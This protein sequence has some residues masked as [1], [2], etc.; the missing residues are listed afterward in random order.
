M[1]EKT[2]KAQT[3]K[4]GDYIVYIS[5]NPNYLTHGKIYKV[6]DITYEM[7]HYLVCVVNDLGDC[8]NF[9]FYRFRLATLLEKELAEC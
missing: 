5:D 6:V 3:F 7:P 8:Q 4:E 1:E 2:E 9:F